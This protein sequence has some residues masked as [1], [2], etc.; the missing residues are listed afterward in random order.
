MTND[1][2][3]EKK[4]DTNVAR[5]ETPHG[6]LQASICEVKKYVFEGMYCT[7]NGH[8]CNCTVQHYSN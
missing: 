2:D 8:R 1:D 7:V 5:V 6:S 3:E 4:K